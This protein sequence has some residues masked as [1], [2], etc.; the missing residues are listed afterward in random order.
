MNK[1]K[2]KKFLIAV[3]GSDRALDAVQYVSELKPFQ[4]S[5][6]VLFNV[7]MGV[8]ESYWDLE[9]D[10][11][12]S[13]S[14]RE[15]RAWEMEQRKV[16][17]EY[18]AQAKDM[19]MRAGFPE[20]SIAV[21]VQKRKKGVAR[22]ILHEAENGYSALVIGRKG[23]GTYKEIIVGSVA[24]KLADRASFLPVLM[25]GQIPPDE[26]ILI[27]FDASDGA[28]RAV[29]FVG[30]TLGGF[31]YKVHLLHVIRG[32]EDA[33]GGPARFFM[34]K[35]I[36]EAAEDKMTNAFAEAK[37][38]LV[39]AG[40]SPNMITTKIV[41]GAQSRAGTII[42][43]ARQKDYGT[44]VI[45]RRGH[46]KVRDFFMGRVSNKIIQTIRNRAVWVIT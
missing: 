26:N 8:P 34:P 2:Q 24:N 28:M 29:D 32:M 20:G 14:A 13:Q 38:R 6:V 21:K 35:K 33:A 5:R 25:I 16:M 23:F 27:A 4:K 43:E 1:P 15:V 36:H 39:D 40:F 44:I 22:D 46:S 12:F 41:K 10:P 37:Q 42:D 31:E 19:L 7:F 9:K 3:D 30:K 17:N 18:M 11:Q 45:G